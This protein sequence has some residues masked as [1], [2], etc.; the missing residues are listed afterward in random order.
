MKCLLI[1]SILFVVLLQHSV[2]QDSIV[3]DTLDWRGYYPL[4][5][6]NVWEWEIAD[7]LYGNL[8]VRQHIESDTLVG[9]QSW[10]LQ[11]T[12]TEGTWLGQ[13]R[14][15]IDSL[16][17]RYDEPYGRVLARVPATGREYDYTCDLSGDFGEEVLCGAD[18]ENS[19]SLVFVGQYADELEYNTLVIGSDTISF[20]ALKR[21]PII[22]GPVPPFYYHGVGRL[23]RP[24]DGFS[25]TIAFTYLRIRGIEYGSPASLVNTEQGFTLRDNEIGLYP[26]PVS[27]VLTVRID[28][29]PVSS[30]L[31]IYDLQGRLVVR[32]I[33]CQA[34]CQIDMSTLPPGVY[35]LHT[36]LDKGANAIRRF[37]IIR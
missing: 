35:F 22:S 24:G 2:A 29:I 14:I 1:G 23:D 21:D 27:T 31:H 11:T 30:V 10:V 28:K 18:L 17:L 26:N 16:L 6:G 25:G 12:H 7:G 37:V 9:N 32:D 33:N 34:P 36:D 19:Y 5:I 3:P 15:E 13:F 4:E 8:L 20:A